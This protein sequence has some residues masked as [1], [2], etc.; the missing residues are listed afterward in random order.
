MIYHNLYKKI[1]IHPHEL[2]FYALSFESIVCNFYHKLHT[3][4]FFQNEHSYE[5]ATD[6][7]L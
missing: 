4:N 7:F 2:T 6:L 5:L 3:R 1:G